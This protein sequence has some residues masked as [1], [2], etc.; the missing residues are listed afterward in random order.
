MSTALPA[1]FAPLRE[2]A[3]R[4]ANALFLAWGR[5]ID[6]YCADYRKQLIDVFA[7]CMA[8]L[9]RPASRDHWARWL[10]ERV[11]L[12]VGAT[13]PGWTPDDDGGRWAKR[14]LLDTGD[15]GWVM[16]ADPATGH[17]EGRWI[18]VP[19]ISDSTDPAEALRLACLSVVPA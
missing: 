10:A 7:G 13:A 3:T 2:A 14:W 12:T 15:G 16:F 17:V 1:D 5:N 6:A 19:G 8:D 4:E 9:S 11:G 18:K